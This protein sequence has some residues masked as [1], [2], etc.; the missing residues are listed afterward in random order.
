MDRVD[1]TTGTLGKA[2]GAIGGYIAGS[3]DFVD[4]IRSYAPGFIFTTSLPPINVAG[5][6]ASIS[7]QKEYIGDRQLKQINVRNVKSKFLAKDI[8]V[9][10][11]PSHIVPVLIGDPVLARKASDTLLTDHGIYVQAINYPTVARGEERLRFTVTPRHTAEQMD[12]LVFALD[13]VFRQLKIKRIRD[14]RA[15]GGRAGVGVVDPE[16]VTPIWTDKQLG[17]LDGT[18]PKTLR[19]GEKGVV[20]SKAVDLTREK[21]VSLLGP[22]V[23]AGLEARAANK[24]QVGL[25]YPSANGLEQMPTPVAAAA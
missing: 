6:R 3:A 11:G 16:P 22:L 24:R 1:I 7:Y 2:Y 13:Q 18:A 8:P 12:H 17:L 4:V 19:N 25:R 15:E 23:I 21:F 5:A 9:V 10:P 14:W 20:D